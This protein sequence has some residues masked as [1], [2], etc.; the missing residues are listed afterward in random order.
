MRELLRLRLL[1]VGEQ[2]SGSGEHGG[3]LGDVECLQAGNVKLLAQKLRAASGI[4]MPIRQG[5]DDGIGG[6][7]QRAWRAVGEQYLARRDASQFRGQPFRRDLGRPQ[8][9]TGQYEPGNAD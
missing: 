1:R 7:G 4:E 9:A 2:G 3:A 5:L 6:A 8:V